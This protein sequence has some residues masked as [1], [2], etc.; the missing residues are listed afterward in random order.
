MKSHPS[1]STAELPPHLAADIPN[2]VAVVELLQATTLTGTLIALIPRRR[3]R[4]ESAPRIYTSQTVTVMLLYIH[5][6]STN[7]T[8]VFVTVK[9]TVTLRVG[10]IAAA[11]VL[12]LLRGIDVFKIPVNVVACNRPMTETALGTLAAR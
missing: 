7:A 6:P 12:L 2:T 8:G 10:Y 4:Q 11:L 3:G 5:V 9:V 1:T